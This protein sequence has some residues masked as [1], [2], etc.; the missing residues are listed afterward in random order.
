MFGNMGGSAEANMSPPSE[1]LELWTTENR[2]GMLITVEDT[3]GA[4]A[5]TLTTLAKHG[6]SLT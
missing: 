2:C 4:L 5:G 6:V 3:P 1:E